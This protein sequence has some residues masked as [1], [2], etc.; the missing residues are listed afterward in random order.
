MPLT[1]MKRL[2]IFSVHCLRIILHHPCLGFASNCS[3]VFLR[4]NLSQ[5]FSASSTNTRPFPDYSPK[6]PTI[7][8]AE[9]VHHITTTIK[10][11]RSEPLR[12][13][14]K[15]YESK[16]RSDHLIWTLMNIRNDYDLV[17]DF[18]DWA[19]VRREPTLEARCII[20]QIATASKDLKMAHRLILDFWKKPNLDISLSF[21]HFLERLTYTYKDWG[22]DPYVFDIFFQVLVEAGLFN[23]ARNLFNK[24]LSYGLVI[25]VDS[26][27][28]FLARLASSLDRIK[29][30]IKA[31]N[32]YPE[33]GVYWNTASYNIIIHSLC[34]L[35][36][37]KEAHHLLVQ[38]ELRGCIPDVVS[39]STIISRYCIVG[40][41]QKALKLI[42]QMK[43]KG[44]KPNPYTYSSMVL[45]LCKTG[46]LSEAEKVLRE[47]TTQGVIPDNVVYTTLIDGFC[48][49]GNVSAACRLFD[50]MQ[51]RKIDPDF[52][53]YTTLIHGFCQAGK[54]VDAD[55]L[56]N[57]MVTKGL[58]PDEVTYT[59]LID[60]YCKAG[61]V[62]KAFSLHNDMV[63]VG[64]TPNIVTYTVLADGLCKQG[65]VDTANELLQEMCMKGLQLNVCTYNTIVNG[66]CK[67][68]NITEAEKLMEEM[69]VAGPPPDTFTYTTLVDAYCKTGKMPIAH[70]L[71]QEMLDRGLQPTVVT[72]NVLMNG[73]CMSGMLEDGD[74]LLKWMLKKGIMPNATTYNSLMKQ[75]SIKN[76]M[77]ITTGIYR[78]MCS[79]GVMPDGNTYNILI[80][81]HCKARN[82]KEAEFLHREMVG[83]G[84]VP[85]ASSYN[86]LIKGFYKRKKIAEARELFEE[87]RRQGPRTEAPRWLICLQYLNSLVKCEKWIR[88]DDNHS[89][90][91]KALWWLNRLIGRT[92]KVTIDWPYP[93]AEGRLFVLKV[94]AGLEGY[95]VNVDRRH[96]T[97]FPYCTGFVLEDATRLF[98]NGDI[99]V[100]W[101]APPLPN[102]RVELFIGILSAGNHF[103]ERMAVRKSMMQHKLIKYS[104]VVARFFVALHG[105]KE[106]NVE[107]NKEADYFGDIVIVP[108]MDNYNI[109]VF[110]TI[111]IC[112]YGHQTVAA[113]HI[114]KC[115]DDTFV[116]VEWPEE[117]YPAY[118]KGPG[119]IIS[120][121]IAEFIISEFEKQKLRLFK[122]EDVSM[123]MWVEQFNSSK[124]VENVCSVR[125]CQFGCIDDYYTA[126]YQ[127]PRQMM[128][129]WGKLQQHG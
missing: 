26:C 105:S 14:L 95:H 39:Y 30:A 2:T 125:F 128:C 70:S 113:K 120:S 75:Y 24:L 80:K 20:V 18:F 81:G 35:R 94:S 108:Y 98:V 74:R 56:F 63:Q 36:K 46:K 72:F 110:K 34:E 4:R 40:D 5:V 45:L 106:V 52:I 124:P 69:K 60:G 15:P 71:L 116:R 55:K 66:L 109:V 31:F 53:A 115:D 89:E 28:L 13:V 93:F 78:E 68:G 62:K 12:R 8:D 25:S 6:K 122:I 92:K 42:E 10:L 41:L 61:E 103:A 77:R 37:I 50:E 23:E 51:N 65:E 85:T 27:N 44:L 67:L 119:Y 43:I 83:K 32:E 87:M 11:R 86:A 64:L 16:F 100:Q 38:M 47:M 59:A 112:Q 19:C 111:A 57:E 79:A 91:S 101:K 21:T 17:L 96:V 102:G 97:S 84:F 114:M 121:D 99:D 73:F 82:I 123:G 117:D 126:H 88:G 76:N 7:K 48:K 1:D 3:S 33:V 49:L 58:E 104:L 129:M 90:E 107:L 22:S 9:L 54:M 127:S 29:M 118:A